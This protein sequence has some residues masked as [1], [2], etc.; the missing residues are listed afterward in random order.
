MRGEGRSETKC[1]FM[2]KAFGLSLCVHYRIHEV[3]EHRMPRTT[4]GSFP[5]FRTL[6]AVGRKDE[7]TRLMSFC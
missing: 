4:C 5:K 1:T 6:D 7:Q 2:L 3:C